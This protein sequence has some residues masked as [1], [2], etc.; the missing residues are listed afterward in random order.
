[1]WASP[2]SATANYYNL[3][4]GQYGGS[5]A[6]ATHAIDR[7]KSAAFPNC[8]IKTGCNTQPGVMDRLID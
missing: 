1:M 2:G 8:I 6:D 3:I 5:D 7:V 4:W